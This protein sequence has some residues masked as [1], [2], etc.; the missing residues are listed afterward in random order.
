MIVA[1]ES[2]EQKCYV[3][4]LISKYIS[5]Q[6][7]NLQKQMLEAQYNTEESFFTTRPSNFTNGVN[8]SQSEV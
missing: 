2:V 6:D 7:N 4:Y 1:I 3:E 5:V 8:C